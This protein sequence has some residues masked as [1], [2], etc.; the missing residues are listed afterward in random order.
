MNTPLP[1][2]MLVLDLDGTLTNSNK[3]ISPANKTALRKA[4]EMGIK[5]VLA[6]GRPTRGIVPLAIELELE[7]FGGYILSY[8]GARII[9]LS[10]NQIVF[11][12]TLPQELVPH[13]Y[14][15]AREFGL[16]IVS[17]N[18][19][20]ILT[21]TPENEFIQHEAWLN[22]MQVEKVD[23]FVHDIP[24]Q[25]PK[26]LMVGEGDYLANVEP[27]V[28]ARFP[29]L[30]V[31]RSEPF[32]LEVMPKGVDKAQS[33]QKLLHHLQMDRKQM[34]AFGDGFNDLTMIDFAGMG[35]AMAN[36]QEAVKAVA[37]YVTLHHN[38][39]GVAHAIEKFIFHNHQN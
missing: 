39:D 34:M 11:E 28:E 1:Y 23:D 8:N 27:L 6:S 18:D 3:E 29:Q 4:M 15:T 31:Y 24:R 12:Q 33:L 26:C 19:Q 32:F 21:E 2:T 22:R 9:D 16:G 7:K 25:V 36:A 35:V 13:L 17:Y 14:H 20:A 38:D 37:N 30:S 5:V 10:R